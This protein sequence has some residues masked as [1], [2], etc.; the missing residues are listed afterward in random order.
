M[1]RLEKCELLKKMGYTYNPENG[2]IY[3]KRKKELNAKRNGYIIITITNK[4]YSSIFAHHFAWYM[5]YGNVDFEMLDHINQIKD[6]NRIVNL[7]LANSNINQQNRL[8][9]TKGY[10]WHKIK[11]KWCSS[12]TTN[13]QSTYLGCFNLEEEARNAY[14]NAKSIYHQI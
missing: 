4:P 2:K 5:T 14:L 13:N 6:D 11:K 9:T 3:G 12:I 1:T 7:R 8:K 10:R